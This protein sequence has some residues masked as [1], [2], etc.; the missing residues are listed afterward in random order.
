[1]T[2]Y[3]NDILTV[4]FEYVNKTTYP[5]VAQSN[6]NFYELVKRYNL[7]DPTGVKFK[8]A[9]YKHN[10]IAP[11]HYRVYNFETIKYY[12][13]YKNINDYKSFEYIISSHYS[14]ENIVNYILNLNMNILKSK[15]TIKYIRTTITKSPNLQDLVFKFHDINEIID[16]F[17][18]SSDLQHQYLHKLSI[19]NLCKYNYMSVI[20]DKFDNNEIQL[21]E[22]ILEK[23]SHI[24]CTI[25]YKH[26]I[27]LY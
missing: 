18:K 17:A 7:I 25:T 27:K 3:N 4:V 11:S 16:S 23:V 9:G 13:N 12:I 5:N 14:N 1:M 6:K 10:N 19:G 26:P 2:N 8:I 24:G 22:I 15:Q 20:Q 21:E